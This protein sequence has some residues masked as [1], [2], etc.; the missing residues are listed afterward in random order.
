MTKD[1]K[2]SGGAEGGSQ[3]DS[4]LVVFATIGDTTWRMFVPVLLGAGI[5]M[6]L[7]AQFATKNAAIIG[8]ILGLVVAGVL[9]WNQYKKVTG[10]SK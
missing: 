7:D 6:W 1:D 2:R 8:S 9:V 5:G 10:G 3:A 4:L